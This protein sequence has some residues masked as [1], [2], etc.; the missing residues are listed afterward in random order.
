MAIATYVAFAINLTVAGIALALAVPTPYRRALAE[1]GGQGKC[2]V[3]SGAWAVYIAIAL[4]GMAALGGEVVWTRL[5]SLVLGGTVYTFSIILAVFLVGLGI[6]S[7]VGAILARGSARVALGL[8]QIFLTLAIAWTAFMISESL[9]YWPIDP[10]LSPSP[11]YTFQLDLVRCL[12][13]FC[14]LHVYGERVFPW[15]WEQ[16]PLGARI[17]DGW[18]VGS[19]RPTR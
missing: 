12:W 8:C 5:L 7:S 4:S 14:P 13:A 11:W 1:Q 3:F 19:T 9:P 6:G 16:W 17:R 2:P 15:P 10:R 18:S